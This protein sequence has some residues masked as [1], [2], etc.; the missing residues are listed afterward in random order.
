MKN[1]TNKPI[2]K[3][4]VIED[5][6]GKYSITFETEIDYFFVAVIAMTK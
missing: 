5:I 6:I 4:G 3:L 2:Y 1:V